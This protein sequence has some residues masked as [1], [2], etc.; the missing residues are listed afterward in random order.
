MT[1]SFDIAPSVKL[2]DMGAI[3]AVLGQPGDA[4][5]ALIEEGKW[6]A[7]SFD[8]SAG[9]GQRK[10]YRVSRCCLLSWTRKEPCNWTHGMVVEM[11]VGSGRRRLRAAELVIGWMLTRP[12]L[13][14]LLDAGCLRG[15]T[16]ADTHTTW[17]LPDSAVAFLNK[18]AIGSPETAG[19]PGIPASDLDPTRLKSTCNGHAKPLL[20]RNP[21][22]EPRRG[23]K[24]DA[25]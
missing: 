3:R 17:I 12:H 24:L 15:E 19:R 1:G 25:L 20:S 21:K 10:A 14:D 23:Q 8:I 11:A 7:H 6:L 22:A 4:I 18:R 5:I 9:I 2:L 16:E 13:Q